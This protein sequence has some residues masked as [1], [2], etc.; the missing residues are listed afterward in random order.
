MAVKQILVHIHME[1]YSIGNISDVYVVSTFAL[2]KIVSQHVIQHLLN[3]QMNNQSLTFGL[4]TNEI[5]ALE[6]MVL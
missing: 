3:V 1:T 6:A 4:Y 5:P 2:F